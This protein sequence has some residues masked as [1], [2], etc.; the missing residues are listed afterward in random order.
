MT[1][2]TDPTVRK[3]TK[4]GLHADGGGLYLSVSST[5]IDGVLSKSWVVRYSAPSG[6]RRSTGIGSYPE[7]GLAAARRRA[8]AI[9][10]TARNGADPLEAKREAKRAAELAAAKAISFRECAEKFIAAHATSW[11]N[12]KH[13][14]QWRSTLSTYVYP[15]FGDLAVGEVDTALVAKVLDPIWST[16]NETASRIR[17]RI[18]TVL[19]WA[20]TRGHR[21]GENP[22]RWKGHLQHTLPAR[23]KVAR[24]QHHAA[25]PFD[26]IALFMERLRAMAGVSARALEFAILTAARTGETL[27]AGWSEIDLVSKVWTVPASRMKAGRE[28]RVPLSDGAMRI[29]R[30]LSAGSSG[31]FVF[32][33]SDD[34]KPLSNMALLMTLRRVKRSDLTVH[35]FRS[36]FRDW[37]AE[38]TN[39][40]GEV[41]EAALAHAVG[42]KVE[43]AYRRGD[44]FQKRRELMN[45]WAAYCELKADDRP[46]NLVQLRAVE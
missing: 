44:L 43:A 41:A 32:A 3:C 39:C 42:D 46:N 20:K 11:R 9:R 23:R 15:V 22:A 13:A 37:A 33:S 27:G 2:L 14:A 8:I 5:K 19:D 16:K 1:R 29:L 26:E 45:A 24:V 12:A 7:V 35:G 30:D 31:A 36:T 25:L 34:E 4:P 38:C 28:H 17:G 6:R 10:D 18:E 40:S 21:E